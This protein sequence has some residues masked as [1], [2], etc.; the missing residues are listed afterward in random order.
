MRNCKLRHRFPRSLIGR[1]VKSI[2]SG[3]VLALLATPALAAGQRQGNVLTLGGGVDV[4]PRYSGSD[5]S[6]VTAAQVVD[7]AMANGFFIST[8]R[9]LGYGNRVGNL[10]YSAALSYRAGRKDRDVSSDSIASGSDY[11]RGMGDVKGSAVVVPGLGYRVTD[12]LNVQLQAE[13]PVSE[14]DN[15]EAV[16][17]GIASPLYTSPENSVTLALTGSWGSSKYMQTYYGVSAAQ[18]AASGFARHD[19]GSGIYAYSLNLDWTHKLTSR[20]SLLAAAG[21]TQLTGEAGDSPIVQ[22]KTSPVGS[23]KVTYSF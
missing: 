23:L 16:H 5:K 15:G 10:D 3:A 11:L 21:V 2:L 8:T 1:S 4:A 9:G 17:F 7:Y 20:W 6:R 14:R 22:R 18:S 13:V 19:A 12:W